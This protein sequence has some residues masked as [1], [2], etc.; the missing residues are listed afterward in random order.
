[1]RTMMRSLS[2]VMLFSAAGFASVAAAGDDGAAVHARAD[3]TYGRLPLSFEANR[4]Q[5]DAKVRFLSRGR[6]YTLFLTPAGAVLSL[7]GTALGM[8]VVGGNARSAIT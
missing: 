6:G 8:T 3:E 4:G 2:I 7:N 5:T 1:M